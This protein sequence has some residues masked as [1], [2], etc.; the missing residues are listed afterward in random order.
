MNRPRGHHSGQVT[1]N[2]PHKGFFSRIED[3]SN[4]DEDGYYDDIKKNWHKRWFDTSNFRERMENL[5]LEGKRRS[6]PRVRREPPM[7][8]PGRNEVMSPERRYG[9]RS[10]S[11]RSQNECSCRNRAPARS[12]IHDHE[13]LNY[14]NHRRSPSPVR[15]DYENY[16]QDLSLQRSITSRQQNYHDHSGR[17]SRGARSSVGTS[18]QQYGRRMSFD[19]SPSPSRAPGRGSRISDRGG[20]YRDSGFSSQQS[21]DPRS[22]RQDQNKPIHQNQ[23]EHKIWAKDYRKIANVN[24]VN[25]KVKHPCALCGYRH[26]VDQC[27]KFINVNN[28]RK[29]LIMAGRCTRCLGRH[30]FKDCRSAKFNVCMYCKDEDPNVELH[31]YGLCAKPTPSQEPEPEIQNFHDQ[32][33]SYDRSPVRASSKNQERS[34]NCSPSSP[35]KNHR[36]DRRSSFLPERNFNSRQGE[37][38]R[39]DRQELT[40]SS[41]QQQREHK[42]RFNNGL[43]RRISEVNFVNEFVKHPCVLCGNRHTV[44]QCFKIINVNNRREALLMGGR[45]TRCLGKHSFQTCRRVESH[46]C[47]YCNDEDPNVELHNYGLCPKPTPSQKPAEDESAL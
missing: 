33:R 9:T 31:N 11:S 14:R 41:H 1:T 4:S 32:M 3:S 2:L 16:R 15:S 7:R 26:S 13:R 47:R 23:R 42:K 28:R 27:F 6:P 22:D 44:D 29:A 38:Q 18:R 12:P 5:T 19:R 30:S 40:D 46:V 17:G 45:C 20:D 37:D 35:R 10:A 25:E 24:F 8:S 39:R 34:V 36:N 21:A 43:Y